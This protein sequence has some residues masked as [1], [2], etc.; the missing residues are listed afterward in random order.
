MTPR[1]KLPVYYEHSGTGPGRT[2]RGAQV[3]NILPN[4][5]IGK[6]ELLVLLGDLGG[7]ERVGPVGHQVIILPLCRVVCGLD[8]QV[9]TAFFLGSL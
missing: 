5:A 9:I 2:G 4:G 1:I 8:K 7:K 3:V 6:L